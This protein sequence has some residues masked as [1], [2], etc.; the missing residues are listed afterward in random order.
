MARYPY[1]SQGGTTRNQEGAVVFGATVSVYLAGTTT[2]AN[3]YTA[4]SGGSPVHSIVSSTTDGTFVL[5]VDESDYLS[6]QLFDIV[7]TKSI[8]STA[9][10]IP[11]TMKSVQIIPDSVSSNIITSATL[12]GNYTPTLSINVRYVFI[13]D[14]GGADRNVNPVVTVGN[15]Y[16]CV[17]YNAG[18]ETITFDSTGIAQAVAP[19][20]K[21]SFY[22]NG[23]TWA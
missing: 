3:I 21:I 22:Y 7:S 8:S 4:R 16:E 14:T 9:S 13:L 20:N 1:P 19:G 18:S 5:Y 11:V 15:K 6:S 2:P 12:T 23:T 17:I 10:Y